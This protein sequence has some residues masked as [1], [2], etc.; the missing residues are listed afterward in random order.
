MIRF[1][2]LLLCCFSFWANSKP[3]ELSTVPNELFI[4]KQLDILQDSSGG[5]SVNDALKQYKAG[6]FTNNSDAKVRFGFT[7]NVIWASVLIKNSSI[8]EI[9]KV[10]YLDSAWLDH[11]DFYFIRQNEMVD[12][13][14]LGDT[15]PFNARINKTRMLNLQYTFKTGTTQVLM[16]FKSQDP[17]LIPLYL[18]SKETIQSGLNLSSYFYG[19]LYGA[20]IIL[21]VYNLVISVSLKERS[22]LFY[23][24]YLLSFLSLN[25]AYTGHGFQFIWPDSVVFQKWAMI[26]FLHCYNLFGIAFC[27]EFLKL[28][29][30]LPKVNRLKVWVYAGLVLLS[31]SLLLNGDSLLAVKVGVAV[32]SFLVVIF[33]SLGLIALKNGHEMAKFFIPAAFMGV[34]GAAIS[35]A[36]TQGNLTYNTFLFHSIE[37]GMLISMYIL[38]LALAF[39]LKKMDKAR[40]VAEVNAQV[41]YLTQLYNRRAFT[42]VVMPQWHLGDRQKEVSALIL[43]DIDLFKKVNDEHGHSA[44]DAVIKAIAMTLKNKIRKSDVLARWGGEEFIIYLPNT[45]NNDAMKLAE[46]IRKSIEKMIVI[47]EYRTLNVSVSLGVAESNGQTQQLEDLIKLADIALYRAKNSG[48]NKVCDM[49]DASVIKLKEGESNVHSLRQ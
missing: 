31:I 20:F 21:L 12:S 26:V 15:L 45:G 7:N 11:A 17:L 27:F 23:S 40:I 49:Q 35:A 36:M 32:T 13:F 22:Y 46:V 1:I 43:L 41:D 14:F 24:L 19:F 28:K 47:N 5:L 2:L 37:I 33:I 39:N 3:L 38:A 6:K 8:K 25:I 9:D 34:G 10:L 29:V 18:S 44:G 42:S 30:Y 48:R 16:R 4:N